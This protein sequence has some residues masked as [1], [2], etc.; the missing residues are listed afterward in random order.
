MTVLSI[1]TYDTCFAVRYY[2]AF[3][4]PC[5]SANG[6]RTLRSK[7]R[8]SCTKALPTMTDMFVNMCCD[9]AE[10]AHLLSYF[11]TAIGFYVTFVDPPFPPFS[12]YMPPPIRVLL[13]I[14]QVFSHCAEKCLCG[15]KA[16]F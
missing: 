9:L 6:R 1:F 15:I 7:W 16:M 5:P 11:N 4:V 14:A 10:N 12:V 2:C 13:L 8:H 3:T